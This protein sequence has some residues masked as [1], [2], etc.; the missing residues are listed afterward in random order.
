MDND[1]YKYTVGQ[2]ITTLIG[3]IEP[4]GRH[5]VDENRLE[6][7]KHLEAVIEHL[8]SRVERITEARHRHEASMKKI[9][10]TAFQFLQDIQG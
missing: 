2:L 3:P 4:T 6:N 7:L 1:R 10:E 9:G 8:L 5:E